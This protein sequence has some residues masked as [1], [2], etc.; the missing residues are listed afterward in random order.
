[1]SNRG[2]NGWR[3]I[4]VVAGVT[5]VMSTSLAWAPQVSALGLGEIETRSALNERFAAEIELLDT[6]D[7]DASEVIASLASTD[8]FRR[9]G[10][11]RF[12]FLT[13]LKFEVVR[14][15]R[16]NLVINASSNQPI[17]EPYLNFL[18]EVLWPA[19]RLL[20]EYTVLLDPPTFTHSAAAPV[21]A[22]STE[23]T[24]IASAGRVQRNDP[25]GVQV[26][27]IQTGTQAQV[28]TS[29]PKN[30]TNDGTYGSTT[31]NDTLW[32]IA[33]E[34][35]PSNNVTP[36]QTMLAIQ[37]LN[38][39]AFIDNNVNLLKAGVVLRLPSEGDA[40]S[41]GKTEA[42]AEVRE[43]TQAWRA[44][45]PNRAVANAPAEAS[46]S[47]TQGAAID[48]TSRGPG[49]TDG[50][51]QSADGRLRIVAADASGVLDGTDNTGS[52]ESQT[53][54]A[55]DPAAQERIESLAR[56]VD[57]LTYQLDLQ[58]RGVEQQVAAKDKQISLKDQQIS[59][60][61]EQLRAA[62]ESGPTQS[63]D[64][65]T[66]PAATAEA[67]PF[68]QQ[69]M[70]LGGVLG[71]LAL[72]LAGAL[73]KRRQAKNALEDLELDE[74]ETSEP[75]FELGQTESGD[76]LTPLAD[77][78]LVGDLDDADLAIA[79]ADSMQE[80]ADLEEELSGALDD[81]ESADD[82]LFGPSDDAT[83]DA[84]AE[85]SPQTSDVIGEADIYIAYGRYPQAIA[86]LQ[87]AVDSNPSDHAVRLRLLEVC[88]E[89]KDAPGYVEQSRSLRQ[90]CEDADRLAAADTLHASLEDDF[91]EEVE[92]LAGGSD[93][94]S[95]FGA[96]VVGTGA[97]IAA[98]TAS[99]L[100]GDDVSA[101]AGAEETLD[102]F[103]FDTSV[104]DGSDASVGE[105][106]GEVDA[107]LTDEFELDLDTDLEAEA[108][109]DD[110]GLDFDIPSVDT[111]EF[112]TNVDME[113]APV[114][115]VAD[116]LDDAGNDIA[117]EVEDF[118]LDLGL[119]TAAD[120]VA[121]LDA[122]DANLDDFDPPTLELEPEVSSADESPAEDVAEFD[123]DLD[124][125]LDD[126]EIELGSEVISPDALSNTLGGDLGIDFPDETTEL[127]RVVAE[128]DDDELLDE[129][130]RGLDELEADGLLTP[131]LDEDA[132][133]SFDDDADTSAT[134][135]DLAR[136]YIDMGDD[137]GAREILGEVISEGDSSQQGEANELL[138]KL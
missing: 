138:S 117:S 25:T 72:L 47:E 83:D 101:D 16:G 136:A 102:E 56:Q 15:A 51:Q 76:A 82:E 131:E 23:S 58:K 64:Q 106:T 1:M 55:G 135:L 112:A 4:F 53:Q 90:Y 7:L 18:V 22:P 124:T 52:G 132:Q 46:G 41:I 96:A 77:A 11:E 137:D 127:A 45:A 128:T 107:L 40:Q 116:S 110:A 122:E 79:Q 17:T 130:E 65:N 61:Q 5:A 57:E 74:F 27:S 125:T 71:V 126:T 9:V 50:A 104:T 114:E 95:G 12:F 44:G 100:G 68:W 78:D 75:N 54:V 91:R 30:R 105:L 92:S 33:N 80:E 8:D 70:V 121:N 111:D 29:A 118:E 87:G 34:T 3:Q 113:S 19:G 43:Q 98:G 32:A 31:R 134:K 49:E 94:D 86:L 39:N 13:N 63:Q 42:V 36:Q 109:T 48:A 120:S 119:D 88:A 99:L 73:F 24:D 59:Q 85:Q 62:N 89:T 123:T 108:S 66:S 20:K 129:I 6:H 60:L 38:P 69:P 35:L 67:K 10:V 103:A 93:D 84:D 14:N 26:P 81:N 115:G 21:A 133:F 2:F 97:A 28:G 37:R